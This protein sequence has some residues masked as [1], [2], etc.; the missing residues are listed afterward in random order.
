MALD[1][2]TDIFSAMFDVWNCSF[3]FYDHCART[4]ESQEFKTAIVVCFLE[5]SFILIL[6]FAKCFFVTLVLKT[7]QITN[8]SFYHMLLC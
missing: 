4:E 3:L 8:L 1:L 6:I 5:Q 7:V 2:D